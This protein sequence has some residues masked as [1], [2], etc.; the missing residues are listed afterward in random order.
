[1]EKHEADAPN[2]VKYAHEGEDLDWTKSEDPRQRRRMQNIVNSRKRRYHQ[3]KSAIETA[4]ATA[5]D[6]SPTP[7]K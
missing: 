6:S 5:A 4:A 2:Y 7:I 3:C 1:M